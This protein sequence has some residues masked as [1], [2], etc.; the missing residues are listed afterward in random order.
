MRWTKPIMRALR[1]V[2]AR[3]L[4]AGAGSRAAMRRQ[5][6]GWRRRLLPVLAFLLAM[7]CFESRAQAQVCS[8]IGRRTQWA[9][10][11]STTLWL[12]GDPMYGGSY[13]CFYFLQLGPRQDFLPS[14][15]IA[16]LGCYR[17]LCVLNGAVVAV[18]TSWKGAYIKVPANLYSYMSAQLVVYRT[19]DACFGS[20]KPATFYWK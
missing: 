14:R 7:T 11:P 19:L 15:F 20:Y 3:P 9:K 1:R 12:R 17:G 10:I 13:V 18:N 4:I 5:G 2:A 16:Q 6:L 8:Y